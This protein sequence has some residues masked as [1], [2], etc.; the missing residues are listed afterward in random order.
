MKLESPHVQRGMMSALYEMAMAWNSVDDLCW[1]GSGICTWILLLG[2]LNSGHLGCKSLYILL[3]MSPIVWVQGEPD[4][5]ID[6]L[7]KY[8]AECA[9][10]TLILHQWHHLTTFSAR[11]YLKQKMS[12]I[13]EA[14]QGIPQHLMHTYNTHATTSIGTLSCVKVVR[15]QPHLFAL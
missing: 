5:R 1:L 12:I 9:S 13:R 7:W 3:C 4:W 10:N 15:F 14:F 11:S 2:W 6:A 8:N